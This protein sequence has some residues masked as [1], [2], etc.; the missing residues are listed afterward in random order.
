MLKYGIA[1][2]LN[3]TSTRSP[4]VLRGPIEK[5]CEEASSLGYQGLEIQLADPMQYDWKQIKKVCS[6]YHLELIAFATGRELS[7]NGLS[8]SGSR[9]ISTARRLPAAR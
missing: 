2:S 8:S 4:I 9:S 1:C 6:D 7:E 5:L 3:E